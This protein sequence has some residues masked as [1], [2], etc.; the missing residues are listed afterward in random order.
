ILNNS[1]LGGQSII[2]GS[3][4]ANPNLVGRQPA[5]TILNEVTG[6]S[7]STLAGTTEVF[8]ARA[9]VII[10]N[11]N[12]VGC[13]GC[14]F[15]NAGRVT[16]SSGVPIPDYA[17]GTVDFDVS[18]GIVSVTGSG[19]SG[20]PGLS[21]IDQ[22]DL[23][24][25]RIGIDGAVTA[26]DRVRLRAGA[27]R[28]SQASD[29]ASALPG[30]SV[31]TGDAIVSSAAGVI[32]AG[33]ISVISRDLDLGVVMAG[34]LTSDSGNIVMASMGELLLGDA[35]SAADLQLQAQG[36]L[37]LHGRYAVDGRLTA[38]AEDIALV[39]GDVSAGDAVIMEARDALSVRGQVLSDSDVSF[40]A[41]GALDARGRS[42]RVMSPTPSMAMLYGADLRS[43]RR[44]RS[45][46]PAGSAVRARL[47]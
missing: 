31:L 33:S 32:T 10:A 39:D 15:I 46:M 12:G 26:Q 40:I 16:L 45:P 44:V 22:I 25:R 42:L 18:D 4:H 24:G 13:V 5:R 9:D 47:R 43:R 37:E 8:G 17:R 11:P 36:A 23:I 2:G 14:G 6:T 27:M 30:A 20:V 21:G 3:V 41:D 28:Y 29:T 1:G 38:V 19:L 34:H 35:E 7:V